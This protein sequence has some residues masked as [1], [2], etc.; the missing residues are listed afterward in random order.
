MKGKR[1]PPMEYRIIDYFD[2]RKNA[3]HR[4][5]CRGVVVHWVG[6]IR[7]AGADVWITKDSRFLA[8]FRSGDVTDCVELIGKKGVNLAELDKDVFCDYLSPLV[9]DWFFNEAEF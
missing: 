9:E 6:E 2:A 7:T 3:L 4:A 8:K 1:L 5:P